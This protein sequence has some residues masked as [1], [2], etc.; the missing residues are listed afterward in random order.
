MA[1]LIRYNSYE[2]LKSDVD[3]KKISAKEKSRNLAEYTAFME[4]LRASFLADKK[5]KISNGK[6]ANR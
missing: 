2:E 4:A 6:L 5:R 1:N 3:K